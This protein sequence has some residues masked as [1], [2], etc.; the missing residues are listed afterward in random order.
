MG[1]VSTYK[2]GLG[3][4]FNGQNKVADIFKDVLEE[5]LKLWVWLGDFAYSDYKLNSKKLRLNLALV[6]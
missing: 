5:N 6:F 4:C 2:I 1:E 3:S